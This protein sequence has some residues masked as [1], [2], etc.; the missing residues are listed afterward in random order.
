MAE[1]FPF[2]LIGNDIF[3]TMN[4]LDNIC[5]IDNIPDFDI[6][7]KLTDIPNLKDFDPEENLIHSIQSDYHYLHSLSTL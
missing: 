6:Q 7:S 3:L 1:I 2:G 4:G 5:C